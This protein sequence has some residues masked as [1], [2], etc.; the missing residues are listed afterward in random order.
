MELLALGAQVPLTQGRQFTRV[1]SHILLG[2]PWLLW[3]PI[4]A[5]MVVFFNT[6][7]CLLIHVDNVNINHLLGSVDHRISPD[8]CNSRAFVIDSMLDLMTSP[9]MCLSMII[10]NHIR[11]FI[12]LDR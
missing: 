6:F 9:L 7:G 11:E 8:K 3:Y 5:A 10:N 1:T 4:A 12:T 2:H